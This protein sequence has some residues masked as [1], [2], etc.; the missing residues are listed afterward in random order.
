MKRAR[1]PTTPEQNRRSNLWRLYRIRP[2]EYDA[3]RSA[4]DYRCGICQRHES[5][6]AP[7][8]GRPRADGAKT[9]GPPLVVDHCHGT[10]VVR[11][12]L[13]ATCNTAIGL[14]GESEERIEGALNYLRD[15]G[16]FK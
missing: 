12:L 6:I 16:G 15:R 7:T 4:H 3:M 10:G 8:T 14:F 1:K 2:E 13:C 5:E 11:G 9:S